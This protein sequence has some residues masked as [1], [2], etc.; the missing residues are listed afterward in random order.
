[1]KA[2]NMQI[3]LSV[4]LMQ[5]CK[6]MARRCLQRSPAFCE[7]REKSGGTM[8]RVRESEGR[9][10]EREKE[11]EEEEEKREKERS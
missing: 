8:T 6:C 4:L 10:R 7:R 5:I 3:R 2:L 1:M 11:R 9:E